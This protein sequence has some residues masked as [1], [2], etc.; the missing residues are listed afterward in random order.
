MN[1][2]RRYNTTFLLKAAINNP[3]IIIVFR[4]KE[5]VKREEAHYNELISNL[6]QRGY[7]NIS[8]SANNPLLK[9]KAYCEA[10]VADVKFCK[11]TKTMIGK[12]NS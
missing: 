3:N 8:M 11:V 1:Y 9:L 5:E 7:S 6:K 4:N 10:P 2:R 12:K